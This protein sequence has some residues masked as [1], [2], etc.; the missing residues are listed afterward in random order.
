MN[1]ELKNKIYEKLTEVDPNV[2]YGLATQTFLKNVSELN[3]IVYGN[4]GFNKSSTSKNDLVDYFSVAIVRENYVLDQT[5]QEVI[6]KILEIPGIRLADE[7][8]DNAYIR[9]GNTDIL[10]EI[11][12]IPFAKFRKGYIDR[13]LV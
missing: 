2:F 12:T 9:K 13:C 4:S 5:R 3:Y 11:L 8:A 1:E 6:K 10:L 7:K